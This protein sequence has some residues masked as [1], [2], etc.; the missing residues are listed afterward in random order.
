VGTD[1]SAIVA[2]LFNEPEAEC[3]SDFHKGEKCPLNSLKPLRVGRAALGYGVR[4]PVHGRD[5]VMFKWRL[6]V[7]V[8]RKV[9]HTFSQPNLIIAATALHHGLTVVTRDRSDYDRAGGPVL[10]PWTDPLP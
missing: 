9:G 2:I 5:R 7:E 6:L 1:S 3:P 4:L 8:G 10:N